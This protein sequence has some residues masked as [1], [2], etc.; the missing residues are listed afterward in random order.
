MTRCCATC[1]RPFHRL[2]APTVDALDAMRL[3]P[4][5]RA[6]LDVLVAHFP[7]AVSRQTIE[8]EAYET[9]GRAPRSNVVGV[10]VMRLRP[11]VERLGLALENWHGVGWRLALD[12]GAPA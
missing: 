3:P 9:V 8:R 2:P 12:D 11:A 4:R 10:H 6:V 1:G 5:Q 7:R